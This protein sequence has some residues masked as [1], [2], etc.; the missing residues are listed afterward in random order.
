MPEEWRWSVLIP[1]YKN[2]GDA[3]CCGNYK[4]IKLMSDMMKVWERIIEARLRD[5]VE[6]RDVPIPHFKPI[7]ILLPIP[8]FR[9]DTDTADTTNTFLSIEHHQ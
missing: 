4:G 9:A 1:I 8:A 2:K 7:P 6:I 5:G 3:Q